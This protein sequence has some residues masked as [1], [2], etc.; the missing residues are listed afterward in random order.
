MIR[1]PTCRD[2]GTTVLC[3]LNGAGMGRKHHDLLGAW[4]C[5]A[6]HQWVDG[7]Y[8]NQG[9]SRQQRDYYHLWGVISTPSTITHT[10]QPSL[11]PSTHTHTQQPSLT[12]STHTHTQQP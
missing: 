8:A 5:H 9:Y 1:G 6:C 2:D 11:A 12:P 4:G 7:G 10:Q 3:H